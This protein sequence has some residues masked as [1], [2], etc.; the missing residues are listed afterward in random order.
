MTTTDTST[1]PTELQKGF[2]GQSI[3]RKECY[4]TNEIFMWPSII[5]Q[6]VELARSLVGAK[7]WEHA[8]RLAAGERVD[9]AEAA[10]SLDAAPDPKGS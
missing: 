5:F 1:Q 10:A 4:C 2:I 6:P 7:V 8:A 9:Y 3:S